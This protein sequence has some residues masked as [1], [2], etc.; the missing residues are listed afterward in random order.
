MEIRIVGNS[1]TISTEWE[2]V[3]VP[4]DLENYDDWNKFAINMFMRKKHETLSILPFTGHKVD[5][6]IRYEGIEKIYTVVAKVAWD[7]DV[8][9]KG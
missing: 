1:N 3:S 5:V 2:K 9:T 6:A 7:C 8:I 4:E